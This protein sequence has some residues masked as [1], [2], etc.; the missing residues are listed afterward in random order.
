MMTLSTLC[1]AQEEVKISDDFTYDVSDPYVV[2]DGFIK[3]YF[4]KDDQILSVKYGDGVFTFQKFSGKTMNETKRNEIPKSEGFTAENIIEM[5]GHY[6]FLYSVWDKAAVKEQLYAREI[7]FEECDFLDEGKRVIAV[8]GKVSGGFNAGS[9]FGIGATTGG[10]KFKVTSSFD[11]TKILVQYRKKPEERNDALNN[12]IIGMY[13]FDENM[14][15]V[16][17]GEIT[18]PYT[19]KKM[20]NLGY[21]VDSEGNAY[22]L[23]EVFKDETTR[24]T[25]KTGEP[26]YRL[27]MIRVS[28]KDQEL[29][30]NELELGGKFITDV[31]FFEGNK[32]EIILAG[33]YGN[34]F[35]SGVDGFFT[36]KMKNNNLDEIKYYEVPVDVMK[37]YLSER[38]Q[39]KM[40]KKDEKSDLKM[41]NMVLRE[42]VFGADGGI[43]M[44]GER[45]YW[46]ETYNPQTKTT[47]RTY[48][49]QE[50]IGA[51]VGAD[52]E[53]RW[54]NKFPKNQRGSAA[55]GGMGY[56]LIS[57]G[58]HDY[59]LFLDNV[60]N[61][62]L[63]MDK[64][65]KTHQDGQGGFLTGFKVDKATGEAEKV[66]LF[67]TRD[68]KGI[69]LFQFNTGRIVKVN[70]TTFSVECYKKKK[71][72]VMVTV[73]MEE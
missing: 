63:P 69:E 66:S 10:G 4:A 20:N 39:E 3:E 38:A 50:I 30:A 14:E 57:A 70:N 19:E 17:S 55:R 5:N 32:K 49:Y 41:Y 31:G 23:A 53:L 44:Y 62:A 37:K 52:G 56:Y 26:N 58:T 1:M 46:V 51:S 15:V 72:D 61:I 28:A 36:S 22:I 9:I 2:V 24:R 64:Y 11:D 54:M 29:E 35:G 25:T 47:T 13:V 73:H 60:K 48:Y 65:P 43:T 68:A 45:Y 67:D 71:E 8:D 33:F 40:E 7:G 18:M 59:L 16:W 27:E 6:Y 34:D 21:A 42:I 12:D